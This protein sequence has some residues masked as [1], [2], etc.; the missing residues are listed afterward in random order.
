MDSRLPTSD[1]VPLDEPPEAISEP[2]A[3]NSLVSQERSAF[4]CR[5][6][7][8]ASTSS[9]GD[10]PVVITLELIK[11]A[12]HNKGHRLYEQQTLARL[13]SKVT[14]LHLN[15]LGITDIANLEGC[16]SL[17]VLYLYNN[18]ISAISGLQCNR[19]LTHLYLQNNRLSDL[20]GLEALG[21]LEKLYLQGN[22]LTSL[23][24][25]QG[26]SA[27]E[28]LHISGQQLPPGASLALDE[29][30]LTAVAGSLRTLTASSCGLADISSLA[31]LPRL[32]TLELEHNDISSW[33]ATAELLSKLPQLRSL[34]VSGN[35]I[36]SAAKLR[37]EVILA[38][39]SVELLDGKEVPMAH[40]QFLL[41][42]HIRKMKAQIKEEQEHLN[43]LPASVSSSSLGLIAQP[44]SERLQVLSAEKSGQI[45]SKQVQ[46]GSKP[47]ERVVQ[48]EYTPPAAKYPL[49]APNHLPTRAAGFSITASSIK[50]GTAHQ[51]S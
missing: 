5:E 30:S 32:E 44:S 26:L 9:P 28:E 25:L 8:A 40:R 10:H 3:D 17:Q 45:S 49:R 2:H 47:K 33:P 46:P 38:S 15:D 42:L 51:K 31:A 1:L 35:P 22:Q 16:G 6:A 24:G 7:T 13:M 37:D 18:R 14:H 12:L 11:R 36:C 48:Q 19:R 4:L 21:A 43:P 27:L 23:Q 20:Q 34:A 41:R 39:D 29:A 50:R